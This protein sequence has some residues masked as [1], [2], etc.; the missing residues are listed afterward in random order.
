MGTALWELRCWN[1]V[2]KIVEDIRVFTFTEN[3]TSKTSG[4]YWNKNTNI[5]P[6]FEQLNI[7]NTS[8]MKNLTRLFILSLPI[9][10][11]SCFTTFRG[12]I[13]QSGF[14]I[15]DCDFQI[16]KTVEGRAYATYVLGIGG[17]L[18]DGLINEAKH[19]LYSTVNL[20]QNQQITN[21][22]TDI[23]TSTFIIPIV[24]IQ[25]AIITADIIE[26]TPRNSIQ[27]LNN[28]NLQSS[29]STDSVSASHS[30]IEIVTESTL[31]KNYVNKTLYAVKTSKEVKV[32]KYNSMNEVNV[33]DYVKVSINLLGYTQVVYGRVERISNKSK[34]VVELEPTPGT[35]LQEE[36]QFNSCEKVIAW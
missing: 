25:T 32:M 33:G 24:T 18:R 36:H 13:Q 29:Q 7:L 12:E 4:N 8:M 30:Q 26:F 2:V 27:R 21:I 9:L 35:F 3:G 14:S 23:K 16:I 6:V 22:T 31:E 15:N 20:R 1:Y 5:S 19:N 34:I 11:S 28:T 10:F 17:N